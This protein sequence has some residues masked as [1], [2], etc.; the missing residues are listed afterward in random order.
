MKNHNAMKYLIL[1][2]LAT[3]LALGVYSQPVTTTDELEDLVGSALLVDDSTRAE[4]IDS[5]IDPIKEK[6]DSLKN[7]PDFYEKIWDFIIQRINT[8]DTTIGAWLNDLDVDFK[9]F[10][11]QDS[12]R[13]SLGFAYD[14]KLERAR[15]RERKRVHWAGRLHWNLKEMSPSAKTSIQ[16]TF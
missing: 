14:L 13:V 7:S 2:I 5:V 10:M 4:I 6:I 1:T 3:G 11:A 8:R 9:T 16:V 12:A 15:I